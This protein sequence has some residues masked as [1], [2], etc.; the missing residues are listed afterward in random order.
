MLQHTFCHLPGVGPVHEQKLW[1]A[2]LTTWHTLLAECAACTRPRL[3]DDGLAVLRESVERYGRRDLAYFAGCLPARERWRLFREARAE[4]VFLD[5]ETTGLGVFADIT[6]VALYDGRQLRWFVAGDNLDEVPAALACYRLLITYNG[7]SF[8]LPIIERRFNIRLPQAHIDLRHLLGSLG[9]RGGLKGCERQLGI[10]RPGLEEVDGHFAVLLWHHF[11]RT[12]DRRALET[13]LAYNAQDT[14]NLELLM[15]EA[16]N[17]KVA[18][19]P[20]ADLLLPTPRVHANPF[21][22]DAAII[23]R[24][25]NAPFAGFRFGRNGV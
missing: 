23:R 1:Q 19:T 9:L 6:T 22:P 25:G 7:S 10:A 13:L 2:G 3:R 24:I 8:D 5:I 21:E 14:L 16:H 11:R 18:A 4:C 15:V 17:R 12:G 20:F